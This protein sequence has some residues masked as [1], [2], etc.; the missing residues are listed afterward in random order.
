MTFS[1]VESQR[2][3]ADF[4]SLARTENGQPL[5]YLDGPAGTQVPEAVLGAIRAY[6]TTANANT[7]GEFEI[8]IQ[9]RT[10]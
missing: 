8:S 4:P 5:A 2:S 1:A 6:Y 10:T 3:R 9:T 7:C